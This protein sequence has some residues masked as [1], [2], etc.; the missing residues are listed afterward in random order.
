[1]IQINVEEEISFHAIWDKLSQ[2]NQIFNN[3]FG[4]LLLPSLPQECE[5]LCGMMR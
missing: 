1:M 3:Y 2:G 4:L 5:G